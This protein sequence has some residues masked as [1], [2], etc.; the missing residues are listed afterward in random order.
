MII[1]IVIIAF[2]LAAMFWFLANRNTHQ[3]KAWQKIGIIL[4]T[5]IAVIVV[6]MPDT[7]N[8]FAHKLGV[9]RGADLLLYLLTLAFIFVVLNTYI[10]SKEE[11]RR[12]VKIVRRLALLEASINKKNER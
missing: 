8:K 11:Q 12:M 10:K 3:S 4:L 6:W 5:I 1:K 7:S 9:G 2:V